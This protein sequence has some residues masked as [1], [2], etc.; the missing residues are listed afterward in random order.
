[1]KKQ[2]KKRRDYSERVKEN[3]AEKINYSDL[4]FLI[5]KKS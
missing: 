2:K 1:M 3:Q 4:E 5:M